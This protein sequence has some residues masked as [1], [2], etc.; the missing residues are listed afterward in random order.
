MG[1]VSVKDVE[2]VKRPLTVHIKL[3]LAD[4]IWINAELKGNIAMGML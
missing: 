2:D 4:K 3:N 1:G